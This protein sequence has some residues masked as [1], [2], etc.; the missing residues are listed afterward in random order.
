[1]A[2]TSGRI[3]STLN[4]NAPLFVPAA[5][6][7]VED[8]SPEWWELVKTTSWFRDYWFHEHQ[9][10]EDFS[11]NSYQF[12]E[13]DNDLANLLPDT[14]DLGIL[15]E[16]GEESLHQKLTHDFNPGLDLGLGNSTRNPNSRSAKSTEFSQTR[17]PWEKPS[18]ALGPRSGAR[19]VIHQPR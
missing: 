9:K 4:P 1:M 3:K 12:S 2:I 8:F 13:E 6:Q 17:K 11:D 10:L 7:Q 19:R 16:D 14:L 18:R 5:F 15:E